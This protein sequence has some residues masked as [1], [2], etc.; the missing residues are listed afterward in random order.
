MGT[1]SVAVQQG[2]VGNGILGSLF[3]TP[4][5]GCTGPS[6]GGPQFLAWDTVPGESAGM[7]TSLVT[8]SSSR[9]RGRL[10]LGEVVNNSGY[11]AAWL[12]GTP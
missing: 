1:G 7:L 5:L 8:N 9:V 2:P 12:Q 11:P 3:R 4:Q 10:A 6:A